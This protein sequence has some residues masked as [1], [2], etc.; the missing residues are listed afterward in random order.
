MSLFLFFDIFCDS[1]FSN[2]SEV[3]T[4]WPYGNVRPDNLLLWNKIFQYEKFSSN[5]FMRVSING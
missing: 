5:L 1:G 3:I 2:W 4:R